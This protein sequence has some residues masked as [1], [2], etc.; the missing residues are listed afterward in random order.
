MWQG[1][2]APNGMQFKVLALPKCKTSWIP[3]ATFIWLVWHSFQ[4]MYCKQLDPYFQLSIK[5]AL[6]DEDNVLPFSLGAFLL[7]MMNTCC[8]RLILLKPWFVHYLSS[9]T[10]KRL[11][12]HFCHHHILVAHWWSSFNAFGERLLAQL[13]MFSCYHKSFWKY[14]WEFVQVAHTKLK[15]LLFHRFEV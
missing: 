11:T 10:Q 3:Q 4:I 7:T 5:D 14:G 15:S 6:D 1:E 9:L 13:S 12:V 2:I 8:S